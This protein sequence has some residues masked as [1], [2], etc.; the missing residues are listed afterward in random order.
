M[1]SSFIDVDTVFDDVIANDNVLFDVN[2]RS[3]LEC[4][5]QCVSK[6]ECASFTYHQSA[7]MRS[8]RGYTQ[9]M[10]TNSLTTPALGARSFS[11]KGPRCPVSSGFVQD[12]MTGLC[13]KAYHD[14]YNYTAARAICQE[15]DSDF[16]MLDTEDKVQV[17]IRGGQVLPG[18]GYWMG[19][20]RPSYL[21]PTTRNSTA[22]EYAWTR[23]GQF[24]GSVN[25]FMSPATFNQDCATCA[26]IPDPNGFIWMVY[27]CEG[28][29]VNRILCEK[30]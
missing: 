27:P 16:I 14:R 25:Y 11:L 3:K 5:N 29:S 10:T 1:L 19:L 4:S 9:M 2:A 8:C 7:E 6:Q 13:Y 21:G 30:L 23:T 22:S 24:V 20:R 15:T 26:M 28:S 18:G 12:A 17:L